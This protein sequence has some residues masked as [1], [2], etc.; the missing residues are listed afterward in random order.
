GGSIRIDDQLSGPI[1]AVD[2]FRVLPYGGGVLKVGIKGRLLERVLN[3]GIEA[4]GK[5]AYLQR[6]NA[7]KLDKIWM[8]KNRPLDKSKTYTVAFS[9]YLLKGLD[10]PFLTSNNSGISSVIYPKNKE[11]AFDI[12]KVVINYLKTL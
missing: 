5:G 12:R 9:D 2:I 8:I 1:T 3:Y 11:L 6:F 10:I 7:K 4:Q